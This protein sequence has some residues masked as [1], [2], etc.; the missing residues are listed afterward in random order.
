MQITNLKVQLI[1]TRCHIER[2]GHNT[3]SVEKSQDDYEA[4]F[5]WKK[6][7]IKLCRKSERDWAVL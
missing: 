2:K 1:D 5:S 7:F 4:I 6:D 3:R